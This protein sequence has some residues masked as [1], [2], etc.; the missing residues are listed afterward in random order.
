MKKLHLFLT[1]VLMSAMVFAQTR[2]L[3]NA[4]SELK[5]GRLDRAHTAIRAAMEEPEN[6]SSANAWFSQG[7]IYTAIA[8]SDRP[9][10][11]N[12]DRNA[13]EF[14]FKSFQ[15]AFELD[16]TGI[17]KGLSGIELSKLVN[18]AYDLGALLYSEQDFAAAAAAFKI[19]VDVSTMMDVVDTNAIFNTAFCADAAGNKEMAKEYY[20]KLVDM[21]ADQ[22]AAYTALAVIYRDEEKFEESGKY[23][24]LAAE[25]FPDN[26]NAMINAASIHL[27][28]GNSERASEILN[29][30]AEMYADNPVVW[31]AKGVALDQ[32]NMADEAEA[33][34]L[35]AIELRPDFFDAIFNLA[36]HYV[37]RGV[38]IKAEADALPFTEEK[39]YN[40]MTEQANAIFQ[41]AIPMLEKAMEMEPNNIPVMSTLKDIYVHLRMMDKAT[42]LNAQIEKLQNR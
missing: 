23:A 26:Y 10:Y 18:A 24:D 15:R 11:K 14:A 28:N 9:E 2:N 1:F 6:Q 36:A 39:K 34:Y 35:K 31:F 29:K 7:K 12:L 37:T 3:R 33:A 13:I 27:M 38:N 30:M 25:L 42:E 32:M 21:R 41:K 4:D 19:S 5:R 40:E 17:V 20:Q 8:L 16:K 22:P